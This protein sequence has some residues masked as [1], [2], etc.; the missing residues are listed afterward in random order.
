M[1]ERAESSLL[2]YAERSQ[3]CARNLTK[4]IFRT[5][6]KQKKLTQIVP[7]Y[8]FI[9]TKRGFRDKSR[10]KNNKKRRKIWVLSIILVILHSRLFYGVMVAQQVLVLF[11]VVR[12]RL[13]QLKSA[14]YLTIC[15]A[16]W[17]WSHHI[18]RAKRNCGY[19]L[20]RTG[21]S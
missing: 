5:T 1:Q 8:F 11:V 19:I 18:N 3:Q 16:F 15:G 14:V 2:D 7:I 12:I 20:R 21:I 13:E 4:L 6:L 10:T 9:I 17:Y